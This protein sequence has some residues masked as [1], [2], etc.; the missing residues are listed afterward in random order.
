M[1]DGEVPLPEP[2]PVDTRS[3]REKYSAAITAWP[4]AEWYSGIIKKELAEL[5]AN[6]NAKPNTEVL[7]L[8]KVLF[9]EK[10]MGSIQNSCSSCHNP[11]KFWTDGSRM[12]IGGGVRNTPT[13]ENAWHLK[14]HLFHDGRAATYAEQITEAIESPIEMDGDLNIIPWILSQIPG[15]PPLFEAAYGS[16]SIT[17]ERILD[18]LEVYTLSISSG[19]TA[20]DRFVRGDYAALT[21]KEIEGL[22]LFRTKGKC[23]NCHN[24]PFFT[25]LQYHNL[26]YAVDF[27]G[28]LD[29]GRYEVTG[30]E[31]DKGKLRT[32][33][34]RNVSNTA[35]YWHNGEIATL[36]EVIDLLNRGMPHTGR[37][38][39]N[40]TLSPHIRPLQLT[41]NEQRAILAFLNTLSSEVLKVESPTLPQ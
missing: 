30:F 9:F 27:R 31:A 23:I 20:F 8:G 11:A 5:P 1:T 24:G 40:G 21:D 29:N 19:E 4:E 25:D 32:P 13:I 38:K 26:G 41:S 17:R 7:R 39:I 16:N 37:Q 36:E 28:D 12:A 34:L 15:Y 14:G 10:R 18:A 2:E 33:G 3:T 35:P 6:P 22:H